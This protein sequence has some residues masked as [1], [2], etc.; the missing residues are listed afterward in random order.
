MSDGVTQFPTVPDTEADINAF[1][2]AVN[3]V[4]ESLLSTQIAQAGPGNLPA[5]WE[6]NASDAYASSALSY[7]SQL[8]ELSDDFAPVQSAIDAYASVVTTTNTTIVGLQEDWDTANETFRREKGA[9]D[10]TVTSLTQEE[11]DEELRRI[12]LKRDT[13][14]SDLTNT[15]NR[16]LETL[17]AEAD[18]QANAIL[19]HHDSIVS[20]ETR[21]G[22]RELIAT[23]LFDDIPVLDGATEQEYYGERA[24]EAAVLFEDGQLTLEEVETFLTEYGEDSSNPFFANALAD[25]VGAYNLT[26]AL[27]SLEQ[28][29][30]LALGNDDYDG[31]GVPDEFD[32]TQLD[33]AATQIGSIFVLASGGA[34]LAD[35]D[36]A[37]AWEAVQPGITYD[38]GQSVSSAQV[39][40]RNGIMEAGNTD[41][42]APSPHDPNPDQHYDPYYGKHGYDYI[43]TA[44]GAAATGNE[45][46]VAGDEFFNGTGNTDT[47]VA[48]D[49]LEWEAT[50]GGARHEASVGP[51]NTD[52][53]S[54]YSGA[55]TEEGYSNAGM[56]L[57]RLMDSV[58][59][60]NPTDPHAQFLTEMNED[61][62]DYVQTFLASDTEF[63]DENMNVAEYMTGHRH[64]GYEWSDKGE[65]WA[66]IMTEATDPRL[67]EL[68]VEPGPGA[69][70]EE[71]AAYETAK[72]EWI[73][74][75]R[76][77]G[78]VAVGLTEGYQYGLNHV[79]EVEGITG[80]ALRSGEEGFGSY[81][82]ELRNQLG[83]ILE[84]YADDFVTSF[85]GRYDDS[86]TYNPDEENWRDGVRIQFHDGVVQDFYGD[87]SMFRDMSHHQPEEG[88]SGIDVFSEEIDRLLREDIELAIADGADLDGIARAA[89]EYA[90][91]SYLLNMAETMTEV[92]AAHA[93]DFRNETISF[94]TGQIEFSEDHPGATVPL[95]ILVDWLFPT[96]H[97]EHADAAA[98]VAHDEAIAH[99]QEQIYSATWNSWY[100]GDWQSAF[101]T[102]AGVSD[103]I[104]YLQAK[105]EA[106]YALD[107]DYFLTFLDENGELKPWEELND[108]QRTEVL[109]F[110]EYEGL[111]G[112]QSVLNTTDEGG[113]N[114]PEDYQPRGG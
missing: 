7:Q 91:I 13:Q 68:P 61:R 26:G 87:Q 66:E 25:K 53:T 32:P 34:N 48:Q 63:L 1:G 60:I 5:S 105:S 31:D 52:G 47:S 8:I 78:I 11:Y 73:D 2:E 99:F 83:F 88:K 28:Y 19:A 76:K 100:E 27:I 84:P 110:L 44:M 4:G 18:A 85:N 62:R 42:T 95:E 49:I 3:N 40:F 15:Y 51:W 57:A 24:E 9:L 17:N 96:D 56:T 112:G 107:D 69:T 6:G 72:D 74:D 37:A 89:A 45:W 94:L 98:A 70:A 33:T 64:I 59:T 10:S 36:S 114:E 104:E 39:E 71:I 67:N 58:G 77:A 75:N 22:G 81:N 103:P 41:F 46:L 106:N 97:V 108:T 79:A 14:H 90:P 50:Y 30:V 21:A 111:V 86:G 92:E 65:L 35:P 16:T 80:F 54:L 55:R 109:L 23:T 82:S 43:I 102:G 38:G 12:T 20:P 101:D 113:R 93:A 29:G